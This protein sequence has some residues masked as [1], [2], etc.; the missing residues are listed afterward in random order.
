M[1]WFDWGFAIAI[2]LLFAVEFVALARGD[3]DNTLTRKLIG[4]MKERR[5]VRRRVMVVAFLAWLL[6]HFGFAYF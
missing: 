3:H 4:W 6:W 2:V 5:T 1:N